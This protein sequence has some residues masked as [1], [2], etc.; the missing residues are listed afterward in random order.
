MIKITS[1]DEKAISTKCIDEFLL[2]FEQGDLLFIDILD[3]LLYAAL[4]VHEDLVLFLVVAVVHELLE[5]SL[6][7]LLDNLLLL[8]VEFVQIKYMLFDLQLLKETTF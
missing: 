4:E 8:L 2:E 6:P 3:C 1:L 5:L 7:L